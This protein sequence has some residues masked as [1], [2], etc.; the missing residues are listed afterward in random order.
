MRRTWIPKS[1][2]SIWQQ[3]LLPQI[4]FTVLVYVFIYFDSLFTICIEFR[5]HTACERLSSACLLNYV[6]MFFFN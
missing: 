1:F 2:Y 3:L 4:A 6:Y 5:R